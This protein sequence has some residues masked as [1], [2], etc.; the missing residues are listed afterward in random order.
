[1]DGGRM[2]KRYSNENVFVDL[3]LCLALNGQEARGM[4]VL[5]CDDLIKWEVEAIESVISGELTQQN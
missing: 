1:M 5:F 4:I 2:A 3:F